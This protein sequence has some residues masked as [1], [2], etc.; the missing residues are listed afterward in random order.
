[1]NELSSYSFILRTGISMYIKSLGVDL[2]LTRT[3]HEVLW[4]FKDPLLTKLHSMRPEVDE[5]FG[6]M[7]KVSRHAVPTMGK[8]HIVFSSYQ[9]NRQVEASVR[10]TYE[11]WDLQQEDQVSR[12]SCLYC[13]WCIFMAAAAAL[14]YLRQHFLTI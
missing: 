12:I 10:L 13:N 8:L 2:F 9:S 11:K 14:W 3:V 5:Y 1:M 7:W 4:G 6:L